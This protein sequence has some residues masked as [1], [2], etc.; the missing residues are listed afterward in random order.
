MAGSSPAEGFPA[1]LSLICI[2]SIS[3]VSCL[4]G[5][6]VPE[7]EGC[8][9]QLSQLITGVSGCLLWS[10]EPLGAFPPI[11][12]PRLL[13]LSVCPSARLPLVPPI[14]D[15]QLLPLSVCPSAQPP[16]LLVWLIMSS[17]WDPVPSEAHVEACPRLES[18]WPWFEALDQGVLVAS[19]PLGG[20]LPS[21][22]TFGELT[23]AA[24]LLLSP[25]LW[26]KR[27]SSFAHLPVA[28]KLLHMAVFERSGVGFSSSCPWANMH[29]S[30]RWQRCVRDQRVQSL[31]LRLR[32]C[33]EETTRTVSCT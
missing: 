13:L 21:C 2:W 16:R 17:H 22:G 31:V 20:G 12:D 3:R 30:P 33:K 1:S 24:M 23:H 29:R 27:Q 9:G 11:R 25:S 32:S 8:L 14:P 26:A 28:R 7:V 5:G 18:A 19:V 15:L 4:S 6:M 10:R